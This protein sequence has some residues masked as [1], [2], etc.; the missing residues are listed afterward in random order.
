LQRI[1][2][3]SA[4]AG[5]GETLQRLVGL[6][7]NALPRL[8]AHQWHAACNKKVVPRETSTSR[9]EPNMSQRESNL[10]WLRDLIEHL[11]ACQQQLQWSEDGETIQL[12]TET[13][14]RDL[15]S[16]RRLCETLQRRACFQHA[17]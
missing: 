14:L 5:S 4:R 12:L 3:G 1:P 2:E 16:C 6:S 13:M 9:E 7:V 10:L 11:G 15:D 8:F 17:V